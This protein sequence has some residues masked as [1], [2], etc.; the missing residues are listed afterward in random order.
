MKAFGEGCALFRGSSVG[1]ILVRQDQKARTRDESTPW[2]RREMTTAQHHKPTRRILRR[3]PSTDG[4]LRIHFPTGDTS[5]HHTSSVCLLLFIEYIH[6]LN[7]LIVV[8]NWR[9]GGTLLQTHRLPI[10][11]PAHPTGHAVAAAPSDTSGTVTSLALD[12]DWVVVGLANSNIKVYSARTGVLARTLVGHESGVW[13]VCLASR[14]GWMEGPKA[15]GVARR[16][17]FDNE[18]ERKL[19]KQR[20]HESSAV[21]DVEEPFASQHQD[22]QRKR[23]L[24]LRRIYN[25][26]GDTATT[27]STNVGTSSALNDLSGLSLQA[28]GEG[29]RVDPSGGLSHSIPMKMKIALGIE[30]DQDSEDSEQDASADVT[31]EEDEEN[32]FDEDAYDQRREWSEKKLKS[33]L[34]PP[35]WPFEETA[36]DGD[37]DGNRTTESAHQGTPGKQSNMSFSSTGWGQPNS[38]VVS[39]GCDKVLRVWDAKSG[40][41]TLIRSSHLLLKCVLFSPVNVYTPFMD[42]QQP[43]APSVF[44]TIVL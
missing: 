41:V 23:N 29:G 18:K 37:E 11:A 8:T 34:D 6:F 38:I 21:D 10:L 16:R 14:G 39:G 27:T 1:R 30:V 35:R 24:L 28:D 9:H 5:K 19:W 31:V 32:V 44:C 40:Y 22:I 26:D 15:G 43:F 33:K 42:T 4:D 36:D 17:K 12:A 2:R 13:G 25:A 3:P 7:D 20:D